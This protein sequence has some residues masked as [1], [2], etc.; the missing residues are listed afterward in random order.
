[1][2]YRPWVYRPSNDEPERVEFLRQIVNE[3]RKVLNAASPDT[4]LGRKTQEP[5]PKEETW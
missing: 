1:M 4:F 2:Q 5:F 3:A